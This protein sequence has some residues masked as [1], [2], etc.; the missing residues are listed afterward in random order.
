MSMDALL[1]SRQQ[2]EGR[3]LIVVRPSSAGMQMLLR[4]QRAHGEISAQLH[5][6]RQ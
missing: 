3:H 5:T 4:L 2:R 6:G 1:G